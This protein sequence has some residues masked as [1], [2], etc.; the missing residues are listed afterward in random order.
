MERALRIQLLSDDRLKGSPNVLGG[1]LESK[2]TCLV[3]WKIQGVQARRLFFVS[4]WSLI[5]KGTAD[6][7]STTTF[8]RV[9]RNGVPGG[10]RPERPGGRS[11]RPDVQ[12]D[13]PQLD[14]H[15]QTG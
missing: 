4:V 9:D 11:G 14:H 7:K 8:G 13:H 2:P 1:P 5:E 3:P 6:E 10:L 15:G 12:D